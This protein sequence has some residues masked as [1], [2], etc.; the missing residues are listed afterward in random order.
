MLRM[1]APA[2]GVVVIIHL[3]FR[4]PIHQVFGGIGGK[5]FVCLAGAIHVVSAV[6]VQYIGIGQLYG[7]G[8]GVGGRSLF[9]YLCGCGKIEK[10]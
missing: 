1:D 7:Y 4:L 10:E 6:G 9:S 2:I 5:A 3:S 8:I